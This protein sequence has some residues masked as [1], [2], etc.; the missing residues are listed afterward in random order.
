MEQKIPIR[1]RDVKVK[2]K[3]YKKHKINHF[4]VDSLIKKGLTVGKFKLKV[5]SLGEDE[6]LWGW[7]ILEEKEELAALKGKVIEKIG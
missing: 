7:L 5:S 4:P 2:G 6:S 1:F 3:C